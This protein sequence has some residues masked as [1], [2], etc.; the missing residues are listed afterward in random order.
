MLLKVGSKKPSHAQNYTNLAFSLV[1]L[2]VVLSV[3]F[4]QQLL[5]SNMKTTS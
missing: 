2:A 1:Q 5:Y 4:P 3:L